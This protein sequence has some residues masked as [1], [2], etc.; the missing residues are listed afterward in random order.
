MNDNYLELKPYI[1]KLSKFNLWDSLFI[2][3][4]YLTKTFYNYDIE[5][6]TFTGVENANRCIIPVYFVDFLISLSIKYSS[7]V[8]SEKSL[9]QIKYRYPLMKKLDEVYNRSNKEHYN[10]ILVWLKTY[11]LS[12]YKMQNFSFFADRLYKY[13]FLFSGPKLSEII[14]GK[15]NISIDK[16]IQVVALYYFQFS[17]NY[18]Y[19]IENLQRS[20]AD[21]VRFSRSEADIVLSL[22]CIDIRTLK[23]S[24][25]I[26]F[27]NKLFLCQNNAEHIK[28]P[29]L[30]DFPNAYCATPIYILNKGMEGLQY[31][32]DLKDKKN[33][34]ANDELAK[35]FEVYV[36][37]QLNYYGNR[38]TY[39]YIKE[40][41]YNKKQNKT[42]DWIVYDDKSIVFLDCKLKKLT[43]DSILETE[44]NRAT[45]DTVL[46]SHAFKNRESIKDLIRS[47]DSPL[48]KDIVEIGV[49]LGKIL[50]CYCDWKDNKISGLP[51]YNKDLVFNAIILTLEETFC[52]SS[53]LKEFID[54]IAY[55]Y[56]EEKK[57][58]QLNK[59]RTSIISSATFDKSIPLIAKQGLNKHIIEDNFE[60]HGN[61][62]EHNEYLSQCFDDLFNL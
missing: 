31:V 13:Y 43:I 16:Y 37:N 3:R 40:L 49:D 29:I 17:K 60:Y 46:E 12:Q 42:S 14:L 18:K 4:Q 1:N 32:I 38:G 6:P 51:P 58:I 15:L 41:E 62:H 28:H 39:K 25:K 34:G 52:G 33:Q 19:N 5:K 2:I 27:S 36:G 45:F 9:R 35:R 23:Q 10:D 30:I 26:D 47:L 55:R 22:L 24:I 7:T 8:R 61:I 21:E 50:C 56:V 48:L 53:I 59:V 20:I 44:M 57:G 11:M 54:K